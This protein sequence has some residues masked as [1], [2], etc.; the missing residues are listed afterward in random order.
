MLD[1]ELSGW[2]SVDQYIADPAAG[3]GQDEDPSCHCWTGDVLSA[4]G[5]PV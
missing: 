1:P 2:A 4:S 3:W 5:E